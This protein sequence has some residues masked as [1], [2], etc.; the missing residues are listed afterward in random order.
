MSGKL[1]ATLVILLA[2]A[3]LLGSCGAF[4]GAKENNSGK[5]GLLISYTPE[6]ADMGKMAVY[7]LISPGG[8]YIS[9]ARHVSL[10]YF[11]DGVLASQ[12]LN[13][14]GYKYT[15]VDETNTDFTAIIISEP[16]I[17][18]LEGLF[19]ETT[20]EAPLVATIPTEEDRMLPV[21]ATYY[22]DLGY[23]FGGNFSLT[24][25]REAVY[26]TNV[27]E[28]TSLEGALK[29]AG[30]KGAGLVRVT[31]INGEPFPVEQIDIRTG[32]LSGLPKNGKY[33][34]TV[35]K[36]GLYKT[37]AVYADT[38]IFCEPENKI[39]RSLKYTEVYNGFPSIS[40]E[41]LIEGYWY[42]EPFGQFF[43]KI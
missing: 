15:E 10:S 40:T 3:L 35:R 41:T 17:K 12:Q 42:I 1:V 16:S 23:T 38:K 31:E 11:K 27:Y 13:S 29:E 32:W 34:L 24:E 5:D 26:I 4:S 28:K 18:S 22:S 33:E 9:Q 39:R 43:R 19:V 14:G 8:G 20:D 21:V 30:F 36:G 7:S 37:V 25:D 6:Q 2:A